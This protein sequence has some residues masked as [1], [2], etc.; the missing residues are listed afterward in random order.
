MTAL[1]VSVPLAL[2]VVS[3]LHCSQMCGPIVL[4]YSLPLRSRGQG[5]MASHLA[6][7]AG[8]VTTY[9]LLGAIAGAAGAGISTLGRMAGIERGAAI[10]AGAAMILAGALMIWKL[11]SRALVRISASGESRIPRVAA[12]LL[13][14]TR[15]A[16]KLALGLLLGFLPCGLVY[17]ALLKAA[18]SGSAAGGAVSMLFFGVG[19][20]GAL[21]AIGMFSSAITSRLG[22]HA[23]AFAT[24]SVLLL[25]AFLLARGLG[26][27]GVMLHHEHHSY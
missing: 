25:G 1:E 18:E 5:A 12:G 26:L 15:P 4:A 3:S 2:G 20:S 8:R 27:G 7:N 17:A 10:V 16:N 23:N 9:A 14:S 22:R 21:L 13:Q 6:Y 24:A 19:T 11:P